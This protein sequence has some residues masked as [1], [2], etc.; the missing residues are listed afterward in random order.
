MAAAYKL[1]AAYPAEL[2][3]D[4][5]AM[6]CFRSYLFLSHGSIYRKG[7]NRAPGVKPNEAAT[8]VSQ[9]M[10]TSGPGRDYSALKHSA[11]SSR[12]SSS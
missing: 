3:E 6:L 10:N 2:E 7:K 8:T 4:K 1:G 9:Y 12:A 11:E 5:F